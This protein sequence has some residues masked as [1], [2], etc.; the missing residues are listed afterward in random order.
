MPFDTLSAPAV[1]G[2]LL[3]VPHM[4]ELSRLA[5]RNRAARRSMRVRLLGEAVE[6]LAGAGP[7]VIMAG[8]QPEFLHAGVWIKNVIVSRVSRSCGGRAVCIVVDS[9]EAADAELRWPVEEADGLRV[10]RLGLAGAGTF[11]E[12]GARGDAGWR[13][14][15]ENVPAG[16]RQD[17]RRGFGAFVDGFAG[18]AGDYVS[19]WMGGIRSLDRATGLETPAFVRVSEFESGAYADVWRG[20]VGHLLTKAH[21]LAVGYNAALAEYRERRGVRGTRHPIPNLVI[22]DARV[23][24]PLWALGGGGVRERMFARGRVGAVELFAGERRV[25]LCE[26]GELKLEAGWRIRP[27]ALT[28]TTFLRM[29]ACDVFVHGLGGAKYDQIADGIIRRWFGVEPPGY[30]CAT[31]TLRLPL[32]RRGGTVAQLISMRRMMRDRRFNPQRL[33][34]GASGPVAMAIEARAGAIE[35]STRLRESARWEHGRRRVVSA[36]IRELNRT[37]ERQLPAG[38]GEEDVEAIRAEIAQNR[39]ADD[40]EW[41]VGLHETRRLG[42]LCGKLASPA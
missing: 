29:F 23:E 33:I 34:S 8:H 27:R 10:G 36:L 25:G 21:E 6:S 22:G 24:A 4:G 37:L 41:F 7:L 2:N 1:D 9:D 31:A 5:E 20:F 13:G 17:S 26:G 35:E 15:F 28:L 38:P 32:P 11:E 40:R 30:A 19:R 18:G 16:I 39:I 42:E 12:L 14:W 3:I